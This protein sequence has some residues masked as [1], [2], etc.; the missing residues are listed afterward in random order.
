MPNKPVSHSLLKAED[1]I[2]V[3]IDIQSA[4]VDKLPASQS[5]LLLNRMCWLV[6]V[7]QWLKLPVIVTAEE[8]RKQPLAPKLLEALPPKTTVYD[9][10]IF[11]LAHQLNILNA[12]RHTGRKT[13]VLIGLETDVCVAQSAIGLIDKGF[14]VAVVADATGTPE[15]GQEIGLNRMRAAGAIIVNTKSLFYEW[16]RTVENVN[17]FHKENPGMRDVEGVGL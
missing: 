9:K 3:A 11:G 14:R 4:F 16:L 8:L 13:A 17:R 2:L 5:G 1:S 10:A 12:V 7:A 6:A 15:P